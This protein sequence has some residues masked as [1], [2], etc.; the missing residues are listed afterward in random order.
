MSADDTT[1]VVG[2]RLNGK[3][4]WVVLIVQAAENFDDFTWFLFFLEDIMNGGKL[5]V[6][7]DRGKAYMIAAKMEMSHETEYGIKERTYFDQPVI[8]IVGNKLALTRE[9]FSAIDAHRQ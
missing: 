6:T 7:P 3:K 1:L 9:Q 2:F 4:V 5:R 8:S